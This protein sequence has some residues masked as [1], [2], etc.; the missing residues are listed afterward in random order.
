M[1]Y[2][3]HSELVNKYHVSLKTVHN[4]IDAAKQGKLNLELYEKGSRTYIANKPSN[5]ETVEK[6]VEQG[7]KYRN[8]R[9]HKTVTPKPEFYDTYSRRQIL[10]IIS[11][12]SIH[13][14]IPMQYNYMNGGAAS[15]DAWVRRLSEESGHNN[16]NNSLELL[17]LSKDSLDQ[18]L[19]DY[20]KVNIVDL[21]AGNAYPVKELISHLAANKK[22]NR[23]IALDISESLLGIAEDNINE[24]FGGEVN[25]EGHVRDITYERFDD[26]LVDDM[27]S[28]DADSTVNLVLFLGATPMNFRSFSDVM[29]VVYGSM[30]EGDLL[31]Y[32][33]KP[34]SKAS[35]R[36]F[37][38]SARN[39]VVE[40][41]PIARYALDLLNIGTDLYEVETGYDEVKRMRYVRIRFTAPLSVKF[42]FGTNSRVINIEKGETVLL[43][44]IKHMTAL[45]TIAEFEK[46]GFLMLQSSMPKDRER[47]LTILGVDS[48]GL[49]DGYDPR[50]TQL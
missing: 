1:L 38:F 44:R 49:R 20:R 24:W 12:L 50:V 13:R 35:R 23:Y 18:L 46:A 31:A 27:L 11:N 26:L 33:G 29:K 42:S 15:W 7:K 5:I 32:T 39:Q 37:D 34:D 36:Y 21:G 30:G 47:M 22:L 17:R 10:D 41:P 19:S 45:E 4:W 48:T 43:L 28:D 14:E 40:V 2:F 16:L 6:L 8:A 25:F 9:F 3:K